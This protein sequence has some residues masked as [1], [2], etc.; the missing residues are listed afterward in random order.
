MEFQLIQ[1]LGIALGLGLLVG[2]QRQWSDTP[3][4]G[5]RT[6]AMITLFGAI[7]GVLSREAGGWVIAAGVLALA[8]IIVTGLTRLR[9]VE[10]DPG[11]TT[12]VTA[13]VMYGVGALV[14]TGPVM[15]AVILGGAVAVLLQWKKPLHSFVRQFDE[16]DI[17]AIFQFVLIALV[18]LPLLPNRNYGPYQVLNPFRIW[19]LVVLIVGISIAA[20]IAQRIVGP[21]AGAL[22]GGVL[23][24]L[25]SS[26]ATTV[27]YSRQSKAT[28]MPPGLAS[29]V[30]MIASTIVFVRVMVILGVVTPRILPAVLPPIA[31]MAVF[32]A[33][34]VG[35]Q[36]V[37]IRKR[38]AVVTTEHAPS[39]MK[40]AIIF[41]ALYA[42]VILGVAAG[43]EHLGDRGLYLVAA[44]SGLTD[45]DAITLSTAEL[46]KENEL[47]VDT[48]WRMI[49][50][51]YLSNMVF[52]A[53][54]VAAIGNRKLFGYVAML[55]GLC[56]A[57]GVAILLFWPS[58]DLLPLESLELGVPA[59]QA[60]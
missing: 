60:Q 22:L 57:A 17:R 55:F 1:H 35:V 33:V 32:M 5:I 24:G 38:E 28:P 58:I 49:L 4:M 27:S 34:I 14:V 3:G 45:M 56:L 26:T 43:R 16:D 11:M 12:E 52:K 40:P 29:L 47:K 15:A 10:H 13:L 19:L 59:T 36:Y 42:V 46:I 23:G 31:A 6:F 41:G 9:A 53:G 50:I 37:F 44:V 30:I 20:F 7:A 25:I 8:G 2:M 39:G 54:I 18:I 51:G 21:R 48:G